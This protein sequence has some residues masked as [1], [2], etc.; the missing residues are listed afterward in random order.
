M[1]VVSFAIA[2]H[3]GIPVGTCLVQDILRNHPRVIGFPVS[4]RGSVCNIIGVIGKKSESFVLQKVLRPAR[5]IVKTPVTRI[6]KAREVYFYSSPRSDSFVFCHIPLDVGVDPFTVG[7]QILP[8]GWKETILTIAA[9]VEMEQGSC[10]CVLSSRRKSD[11]LLFGSFL[12]EGRWRILV[13]L[14][15]DVLLLHPAIVPFSV[16]VVVPLVAPRSI[17]V[18]ATSQR[19]GQGLICGNAIDDRAVM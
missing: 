6:H 1:L 18:R 16:V 2:V 14:A 3:A 4:L 19:T 8:L 17:I 7:V 11:V 15:I 13:C 5:V 10:A 12:P 9:E